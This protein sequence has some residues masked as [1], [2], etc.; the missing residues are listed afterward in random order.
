MD[1]YADV[2]CLT[3]LTLSLCCWGSMIKGIRAYVCALDKGEKA[4]NPIKLM[5]SVDSSLFPEQVG[6]Y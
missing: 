6:F 2:L 1:T 4:N 5:L 3:L